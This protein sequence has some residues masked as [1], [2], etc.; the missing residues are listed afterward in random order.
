MPIRLSV[1]IRSRLVA[2]NG[3]GRAI[4][5]AA[6]A[7][8]MEPM[9]S[10]VASAPPVAGWPTHDADQR[11]NHR[12]AG[13]DDRGVSHE[14]QRICGGFRAWRSAVRGHLGPRCLHLDCQTKA[15]ISIGR[16]DT[17]Q[18]SS[19]IASELSEC[20]V[21]GGGIPTSRP[22]STPIGLVFRKWSTS[23]PE[24]RAARSAPRRSRCPCR[25]LGP[26]RLTRR[27]RAAQS[28]S[29]RCLM[30]DGSARRPSICTSLSSMAATKGSRLTPRRFRQISAASATTSS[31]SATIDDPAVPVDGEGKAAED[32]GHQ[33]EG[34]R[35]LDRVQPHRSEAVVEVTRVRRRRVAAR[36]ARDE[37]WRTGCRR[38]AGR[39]RSAAP[40]SRGRRPPWR[41]RGW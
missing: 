9:A 13:A 22:I 1:M 16:R 38:S 31:P 4:S 19:D 41:R 33:I 40:G 15:T 28:D 24:R 35:R 20:G 36:R 34:E 8:L 37:R 11:R 10:P 32:P 7:P 6:I 39:A 2:R 14:A 27:G 5:F 21:A 17:D 23:D 26:G 25:E 12:G 18:R 29:P 30:C 3:M